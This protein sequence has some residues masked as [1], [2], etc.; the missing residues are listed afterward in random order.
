VQTVS[1]LHKSYAEMRAQSRDREL[2]REIHW[3]GVPF[4]SRR[5]RIKN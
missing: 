2:S 1:F 4:G 5:G 3:G